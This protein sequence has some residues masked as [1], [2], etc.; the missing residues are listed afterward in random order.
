MINIL[1][2]IY[3]CC[4]LMNRNGDKSN[5]YDWLIIIWFGKDSGIDNWVMIWLESGLVFWI[6]LNFFKV[7]CYFEVFGIKL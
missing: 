1:C 4:V 5:F 3:I 2:V 6:W 7:K